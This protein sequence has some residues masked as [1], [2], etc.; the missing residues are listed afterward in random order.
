L[1]RE[2]FDY[3]KDIFLVAVGN[4][5]IMAS[6]T[7]I[8]TRQLGLGASGAWYAA[9]R[10]FGLMYQAIWRIWDVSAPAISEMI[11]RGERAILR[12]RYK[13]I[14]VVTASVSGF[15]AVT[16]ALCNS[17]FI[18]VYTGW[19]GNLIV[20]VPVND[21]LLG[22]WLI[23]MANLHCHN[24]FVL[25]TKRVGF[26]RY[27]YFV[28]GVV[29]VIAAFLTA[30]HG[31]LP[32]I[33]ICSFI[34]SALFSGAYGVWRTSRYFELSLGEVGLRWMRPMGRMLLL[35][36]PLA[37]A[38][39]WLF[40]GVEGP[41]IRLGLHVLISGS[42]GFYLFLRYGLPGTFQKELL[43]RA[44]KRINPLLRLVFLGSAQ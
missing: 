9:T 25:V 34:C 39:W 13:A 21:L 14:V 15:A 3:G 19:T 18:T 29:F 17:L 4:Q 32:A 35:L 44:P 36:A 12:E 42:I 23:I 22:L 6:Q 28:E 10:T 8:I 40:K 20:W 43:Q 16:F 24:C 33:I 41:L 31:G 2:I 7:M 30:K 38:V 11:V 26:M 27:V 37:L 1:F 5:L